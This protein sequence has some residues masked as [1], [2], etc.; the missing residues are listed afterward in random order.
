MLEQHY[1]YRSISGT[2]TG[3]DCAT[4][5]HRFDSLTIPLARF[6]FAISLIDYRDPNP[7]CFTSALLLYLDEAMHQVG[8]T[9]PVGSSVVGFARSIVFRTYELAFPS[10][11]NTID[12]VRM[13]ELRDQ[14]ELKVSLNKIIW[15]PQ[16]ERRNSGIASNIVAGRRVLDA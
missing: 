1:A 11:T 14:E 2:Y 13:I 6:G 7:I 10:M 12:G 9:P 15:T 5:L 3:H 16:S 4:I 8:L